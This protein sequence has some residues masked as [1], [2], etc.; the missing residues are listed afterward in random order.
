MAGAGQRFDELA[1]L[2]LAETALNRATADLRRLGVE[3]TAEISSGFWVFRICHVTGGPIHFSNSL[4]DALRE[5][6]LVAAENGWRMA[7]IDAAAEA[8]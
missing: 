3:I 2:G 6:R 7:G 5:G 4:L 1:G 8:A